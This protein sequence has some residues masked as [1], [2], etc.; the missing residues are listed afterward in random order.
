[1]NCYASKLNSEKE[2]VDNKLC[3]IPTVLIENGHEFVIFV[4]EIVKEGSKKWELAL[5]NVPLEEWSNKGLSALASRI[6]SP[7][8]MDAM[9]TRM[10]NQ[11]VGRIGYSRILVEVNANKELVDSIDVLYKTNDGK[12]SMK[13]VRFENDWKPPLCKH[14]HVFGHSDMK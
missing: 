10:C 8:V 1:M 14:C 7:L 4:E 13:S 6:G 11:G 2:I 5:V 3:H 9:T 12:Q